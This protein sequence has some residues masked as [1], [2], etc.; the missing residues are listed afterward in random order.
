L[1]KDWQLLASTMNVTSSPQYLHQN[2][3][4]VL[5]IWGFGFTDRPVD[6]QGALTIIN[7]FKNEAGVS[8]YL[9]WTKGLKT[10]YK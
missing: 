10:L 8:I 1:K 3:K 7:Y 2:N 6:V 4:P 5:V 9:T